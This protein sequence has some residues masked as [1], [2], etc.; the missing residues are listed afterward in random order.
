[1][2]NGVFYSTK[3][4]LLGWEYFQ[5]MKILDELFI[6][7]DFFSFQLEPGEYV[8]ACYDFFSKGEAGESGRTLD[9]LV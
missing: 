5:L 6:R 2:F 3:F 4:K 1:M 9:F 7:E 8:E